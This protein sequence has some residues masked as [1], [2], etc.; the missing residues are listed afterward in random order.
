MQREGAGLDVG[1]VHR[2]P[3]DQLHDPFGELRTR[4][5][6]RAR[7]GARDRREEAR[8]ALHVRGER[9]AED[10]RLAAHRDLAEVELGTANVE[11]GAVAL[12]DLATAGGI[13]EDGVELREKFVARG[14]G[15]GPL[16]AE[17]LASG[18]NLFD[19][20]R[21]VGARQ[22]LL[23]RGIQSIEIVARVSQAIDVVYSKT[24]ELC[25]LHPLDD[26]AVRRAEDGGI[27]HAQRDELVDVEEAAVVDLVRGAAPEDERVDLRVEEG[28]DARV[29]ALA[30]GEGARGI[31][32]RAVHAR[33][34]I[35]ERF[36]AAEELGRLL[37]SE[38]DE[39][40][41]RRASRRQ[42]GERIANA[43]E[44]CGVLGVYIGWRRLERESEH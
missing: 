36:E 4:E 20:H 2:K 7:V 18:K 41:M 17:P 31:I 25:V 26:A 23:D 19:E 37:L 16:G 6:S 1:A 24:V 42:R 11:E 10:E 35:G 12:L 33:R 40:R 32:E 21:N 34:A 8:E 9:A 13:D 5:R 15:H 3:R 14:A 43:R 44:L 27:L 22:H 39:R 28:G 38:R 30:V 29:A